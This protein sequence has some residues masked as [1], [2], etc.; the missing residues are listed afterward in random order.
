M[1]FLLGFGFEWAVAN[2]VVDNHFD[3]RL[4]IHPPKTVKVVRFV[5]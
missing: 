2:R 4:I 1:A 5:R 3:D